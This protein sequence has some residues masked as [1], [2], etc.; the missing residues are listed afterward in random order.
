MGA[1]KRVL[2]PR[3]RLVFDV[4]AVPEALSGHDDLEDDYGFV[5]TT[6]PYAEL[7]AQAGFTDIG[8]QDTTLE[9]L[10]VAGRWLAAARELETELRRAVGDEIFDDKYKS[11][12]VSY[13]MVKAGELGRTLYWATKK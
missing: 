13:E 2:V 3:G 4:V 5:A 1:C 8:S 7:L 12:A 9:Y 11:R 10:E 6:V